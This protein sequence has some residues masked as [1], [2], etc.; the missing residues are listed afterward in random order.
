MTWGNQLTRADL[1]QIEL[2]RISKANA[3]VSEYKTA[4]GAVRHKCFLS[5]HRADAEEALDFVN[6]F[7]SVFIP[8]S[9]GVSDDDGPLIQS[10]DDDYIMDTIRE[11][12]LADSTVTIVLVG[13]CTWA[14]KFVDW[15]VR[16]TL[17]RDSVN[18]LSGLMA[19]TLPSVATDASRQLPPRVADN[20]DDDKLY[21]RWWKYPASAAA[22]QPLIEEAFQ[23][24]A[25]KSHL[26]DNTRARKT[27]NSPC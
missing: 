7:D 8:R 23:A 11:K 1:A 17:R 12:Y 3:S 13:K 9:V 20:V 21:A 10:T 18:R 24:R 14:R 5:Y 22:L 26:I 16:S 19:V 4:S 2:T 25:T 6:A 27:A 15:E